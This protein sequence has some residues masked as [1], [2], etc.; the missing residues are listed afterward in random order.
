MATLAKAFYETDVGKTALATTSLML[1]VTAKETLA[2]HKLAR[3]TEMLNDKRMPGIKKS[4]PGKGK[5][6]KQAPALTEVTN[7]SELEGA[8]AGVLEESLSDFGEVCRLLS[9]GTTPDKIMQIS[10]WCDSALDRLELYDELYTLQFGVVATAGSFETLIQHPE[11]RPLSSDNGA[12]DTEEGGNGRNLR[13]LT[14]TLQQVLFDD[15]PLVLIAERLRDFFQNGMPEAIRKYL[16]IDVYTER[17]DTTILHN[18]EVRAKTLKVFEAL[19]DLDEAPCDVAAAMA[20]WKEKQYKTTKG[21][22]FLEKAVS[23]DQL[24]SEMVK[25]TLSAPK[26]LEETDEVHMQCDPK[27]PTSTCV[28]KAAFHMQDALQ[29]SHPVKQASNLV[30]QVVQEAVD[31]FATSLD[32]NGVLMPLPEIDG[33]GKDAVATALDSFYSPEFAEKSV[34]IVTKIYSL[35]RQRDV[36]WSSKIWFNLL[37]RLRQ[38]VPSDVKVSLGNFV[39]SGQ[40]TP[41]SSFADFMKVGEIAQRMSMVAQIFAFLKQRCT[42]DEPVCQGTKIKPDL[43]LAMG[44]A[45]WDIRTSLRTLAEPGALPAFVPQI[46]WAAP[47]PSAKSWFEAAN[48]AARSASR[49]ILSKL[50]ASTTVLARELAA[51]TPPT[52]HIVSDELWNARLAKQQLLGW[53]SRDSLNTKSLGLF[54][55]LGDCSRVHASWGVSPELASD[56]EYEDDLASARAVFAAAKS[57]VLTIAAANVVLEMSGQAQKDKAMELVRAQNSQVP[58][59]LMNEL[60]KLAGVRE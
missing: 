46:R 24:V 10:Q 49:L 52:A 17:L 13:G 42:T 30:A 43:E 28:V 18:H 2:F 41:T 6:K 5:G 45:F 59:A 37:I 4:D 40:A 51:A 11:M 57:A 58:K 20:D 36:E 54:H 48:V 14:S 33:S 12:T 25:D 26:H 60:M 44:A 19:A 7:C 27:L 3:A 53:P 32:L 31:E 34:G 50:V 55:M 22:S 21:T 9:K 47:I 29:H 1:Q 56:P 23:L 16:P 35:A 15:Q 39:Q 8:A 38:V